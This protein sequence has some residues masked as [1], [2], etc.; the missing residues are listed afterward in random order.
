MNIDPDEKMQVMMLDILAKS[1]KKNDAVLRE[2][3]KKESVAVTNFA[4]LPA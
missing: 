2:E 1:L 3:M 4:P